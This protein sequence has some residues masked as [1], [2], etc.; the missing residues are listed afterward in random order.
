MCISDNGGKCGS[1]D[2]LGH[3]D[4]V[5]LNRHEVQCVHC[6]AVQRK[7]K[8]LYTVKASNNA[9]FVI[10]YNS[11]LTKLKSNTDQTYMLYMITFHAAKLIAFAPPGRAVALTLLPSD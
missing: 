5:L 9:L 11:C 6:C 8:M 3:F 2:R 1:R 4:D 7:A 10:I